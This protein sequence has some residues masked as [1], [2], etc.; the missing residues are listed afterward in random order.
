[1]LTTYITLAAVVPQA[2]THNMTGYRSLL[3]VKNIVSSSS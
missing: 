1:L 3:L 2:A